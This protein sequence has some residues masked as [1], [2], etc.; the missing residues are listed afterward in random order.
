MSEFDADEFKRLGNLFLD[1]FHV[2]RNYEWR[3]G[4]S[5]SNRIFEQQKNNLI[6]SFNAICA[7]L[8]P[9]HEA[10]NAAVK[11]EY[12]ELIQPFIVNFRKA[13]EILRLQYNWTEN[14]FEPINI[15]LVT[16]IL[17][18]SSSSHDNPQIDIAAGGFQN[19]PTGPASAHNTPTGSGSAHSS[20]TGSQEDLYGDNVGLIENQQ[21]NNQNNNLIEPQNI[22]QEIMAQTPAE[23]Y[24]LASGIINYK[25]DGNPLE[26]NSFL[27][28]VDLVDSIANEANKAICRTFLKRCLTG[29]ALECIPADTNT[30]VAF[31]AA[32]TDNIKP[33]SSDVIASKLASLKL[34]NNNFTD[35]TDRAEKL[36]EAYQRGLVAEG[37]TKEKAK[38]FAIKKAI[39]LSRK[40]ASAD[41]TKAIISSFSY[42]NPAE[43][44]AKLTT[45]VELANTEKKETDGARSSYP[46]RNF[47]GNNRNN[48]FNS[49][50]NGRGNFNNNGNRYY[51][52]NY[53]QNQNFNRQNFR[54]NGNGNYRGNGQ[55][56]G[57]FRGN[58]AEHT[59]R[60]VSGNSMGPAN[61]PPQQQQQM[62]Q[63]QSNERVFHVPFQ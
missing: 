47:R 7:Y 38:E 4:L 1:A 50:G 34:H 35:F 8:F 14:P 10:G 44:F 48:R 11:A 21:D 25:Y 51:G 30:I 31:K 63:Q 40:T 62:Q 52:N 22:D 46:N 60:I 24:T 61:G 12:V 9:L 18:F 54:G 27:A 16:E 33:T 23:F 59:I 20:P 49:R 41:K 29:R 3:R 39:E 19:L 36:T 32:L 42:K 56:R 6:Q 26:L 57:N 58:R 55:N 17:A 2:V 45:E 37:L 53:N 5:G 43:V 13:F 15:E 28:D